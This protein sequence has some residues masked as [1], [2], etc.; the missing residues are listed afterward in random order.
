[1]TNKNQAEKAL[2][3]QLRNETDNLH[4]NLVQKAIKRATKDIGNCVDRL[5]DDENTSQPHYDT[6]SIVYDKRA[7]TFYRDTVSLATVDGRVVCEYDLPEHP[8]GTP[9]G[10][11]LLNDDYEFS[12]S[13]VHYDSETDEF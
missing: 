7:A 2:Y 3:D 9:H 8:E 6:F 1:V 4:S 10:A 12:T 11:Y 13:T 5:A